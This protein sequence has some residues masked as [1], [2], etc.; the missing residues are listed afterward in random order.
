MVYT[1]VGVDQG[2]QAIREVMFMFSSKNKSNKRA[3]NYCCFSFG[4]LLN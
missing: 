4:W 3:T 1:L 2:H